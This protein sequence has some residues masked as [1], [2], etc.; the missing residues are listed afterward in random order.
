[1]KNRGEPECYLQ[2]VDNGSVLISLYVQPKSSQNR[3][4]S[5]HGNALKLAI[6]AP[7]VDGKAN[8][9]VIAFLA[10]FFGLAKS[11]VSLKSGRQSRHKQFL[12]D[13]ISLVEV[14][15]KIKEHL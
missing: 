5:I 8:N 2:T 10:K 1:M 4:L 3:F 6:T 13:G 9:A 11:R 15:K 7:P 12:L 14:Q